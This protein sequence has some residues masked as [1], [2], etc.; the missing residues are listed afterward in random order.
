LFGQQAVITWQE[1][2]ATL[3]FIEDITIRKES[4]QALRERE[5]KL[6]SIF[7]AAPV[8]ISIVVDRIFE[9]VNDSF[10]SMTG[11]SRDELIHRN[12]RIIYKSDNE[13]EKMGR[14][15]YENIN[16]AEVRSAETH[17]VRKDGIIIDVLLRAVPLDPSNF[18][19]GMTFAALDI[20]ELK[21]VERTIRENEERYHRLVE[22]SPDSIVMYDVSGNLI[23]VNQK[24]ADLYGV[25]SPEQFITEAKNV[26]NILP[27]E[28]RLKAVQNFRQTVATGKSVNNEYSIICKGGSL[29]PVE[30]NS[31]MVAGPDGRPIAFIS[32]VR[33]ITDRKASEEALHES[34]SK[35][36][37]LTEKS[38][39]GVYL[40]QDGFFKYIN[41]KFAQLLGYTID[42]II[43]KVRPEDI[44]FP[45]DWP[46]VKENL[47][48]R[49]SG[50]LDFMNYEF[51]VR[52]KNGEVKNVE[53][54]SSRTTYKG[55]PAV[56][57]TLLD[58][59]ERKQ[60]ENKIIESEQALRAILSAS[61]IGIG[62][63]RDRVFEWVNDSMC[64]ITGY[65]FDELI[66]RNTRFLYPENE[67]Y[68]NTGSVLYG[69]LPKPSV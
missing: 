40:I 27:E 49:F 63:I 23:T 34:E 53:V 25:E 38:V 37:D 9:E 13:Y 15:F 59:T 55:R 3:N 65:S 30:I 17:F 11:Y 29:L 39:V 58:I 26:L 67:G 1:K 60:S 56:I 10:C 62:R 50:E 12:A 64:H 33:D 45:Q 42:E 54:Y 51:R 61:P 5:T 20:T 32:V 21:R 19:K 24:T 7:V 14:F 68:I 36:R 28:D 31:S 66:G 6:N 4:E 16:A 35:F 52:R 41:L 69:L 46:T 48:K 18:S 8:G 22:T 2:P 43:D 44:T 47:Q 57:G